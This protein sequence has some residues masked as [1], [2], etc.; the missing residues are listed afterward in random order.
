MDLPVSATSLEHTLR[1]RQ[2]WPL[3]STPVEQSTSFSCHVL[4][5]ETGSSNRL[6][7]FLKDYSSSRLPKDGLAGRVE[8]EVRVYRELLNAANLGTAAYYG[9]GPAD[10]NGATW[11][12]LEYVPG[13]ELR[14]CG[15]EAY[16]HVAAWLG[17]LHA[18]F[19]THPWK[20]N[21]ADYLVNHDRDYF[22]DMAKSALEAV[23]GYG[24]GLEERLAAVLEDYD[25]VIDR[26]ID[27][28]PTLVHGSFR[29]QNILLIEAGS[30]W[31]V[32]P[33]DWE[34]A[35]LGS[36]YLDL[37]FLVDRWQGRRDMLLDAYGEGLSV[38]GMP[39]PDRR[40]LLEVIDRFRLH[41]MVKSLSS[42][43][44]KNYSVRSVT[45]ILALAERI[46]AA[47]VNHNTRGRGG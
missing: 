11:L 15:F 46:R 34:L 20:L 40:G 39:V 25:D 22:A 41:K 43:L 47:F 7:L 21:G 36:P 16:L 31:R 23:R 8:R 4:S 37:A 9:A 30:A 45:K 24:L 38:C 14:A 13:V 5:V 35:G 18:H 26:L 3:G 12:L 28:T 19:R 27:P 17:R 29:A 32:C 44:M 42:S 10:S 6:E 33:V 1:Q 2:L